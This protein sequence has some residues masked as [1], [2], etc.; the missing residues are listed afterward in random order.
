MLSTCGT[1]SSVSSLDRAREM[2]ADR[3]VARDAGL[4]QGLGDR[5]EALDVELEDQREADDDRLQPNHRL[6][7][8][9][10]LGLEVEHLD[11]VAELAQRRREVADAEVA[12][13][14]KADQ[15]DRPGRIAPAEPRLGHVRRDDGN[16]KGGHAKLQSRAAG[17]RGRRA[18]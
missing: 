12:L 5:R 14:Q 4:A 16:R 6:D 1:S 2:A 15:D 17:R 10:G 7:E 13:A 8:R 18:A 11:P 9:V 3:E